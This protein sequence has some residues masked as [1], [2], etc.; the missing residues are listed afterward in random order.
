VVQHRR[1]SKAIAERNA[2]EARR[3]MREVIQDGL[4]NAREETNR[5]G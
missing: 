2:D 3:A 1:I 5:L 4:D